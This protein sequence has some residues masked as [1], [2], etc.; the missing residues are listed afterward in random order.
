MKNEESK[1]KFI[2]RK[3]KEARKN[4]GKSQ[5]KLAKEVG[6]ESAVAI[7]LIESGERNITVEVL[8]KIAESLQK[9]IKYF[10]EEGEV[11]VKLEVALRSQKN[12]DKDDQ[13][14]ILRFIELAQNK[15][16]GGK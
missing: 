15:N 13:N 8:G 12:L 11:P 7:S 9:D 4:S 2:G 14:A 5:E 6:F 3:I 1:S 10:F 16:G